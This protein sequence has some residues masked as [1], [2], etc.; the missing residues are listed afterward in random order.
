MDPRFLNIAVLLM[1]IGMTAESEC[2]DYSFISVA[3][4][5]TTGHPSYY[6]EPSIYGDSVAFFGRTNRPAIYIGN[7]GP[8]TTIVT[9]GD[10]APFGTIERISERPAIYENGVVFS[11][12]NGNR[13]AQQ[14]IFFGN[15]GPI[16]QILMS[17]D[18]GPLGAFIELGVIAAGESGITFLANASEGR[19]IFRYDAG[20]FTTIVKNGDSVPSGVLS[21]ITPFAAS[22]NNVVFLASAGGDPGLYMGGWQQA[23]QNR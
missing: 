21:S 8:L 9:V 13:G 14:G 6:G 16:T 17:G 15:G 4:W 10:P 11:A 5:G 1:V 19:G 18:I 23:D 3:D 22:G 7:G 20:Q 12:H 2:A